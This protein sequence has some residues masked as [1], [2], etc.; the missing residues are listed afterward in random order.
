MQ[1]P[2]YISIP[3]EPGQTWEVDFF[4]PEDAASVVNLFLTVYGQGYPI[5]TFIQPERLIEENAA[6]RTISSVARTPRGDIVG[7][8]SLFISAPWEGIY[9]AGSGAVLPEYRGGHGIFTQLEAHNCETAAKKF[10]VAAIMAEPVCSHPFAQRVA[11]N[12][13]YVSCALEVDLMPAAAYEKEKSATG[14]VAALLGFMTR[15]PR[16]QLIYLPAVY[17]RQLRLIYSLFDDERSFSPSDG[18]LPNDVRT[19]LK[20]QVFDFAQVARL[21]VFEAGVDFAATITRE[22]E[23]VRSQGVVVI[24]VWLK[25]SWPWVGQTVEELRR[26]GYFLGGAMPRWFDDDGLL[27]QKIIGRPNWAGMK[28][29]YDWNKELVALVKA[30]WAEITGQE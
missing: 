16:P 19:C 4:R 29:E 2:T 3:I 25:L 13:G 21:A 5:K 22:E 14:R 10:G 30:D 18:V 11:H 23:A 24:Q 27:M 6:R 28:I 26:L 12:L 17:E 1:P 7:H 8:S 20:T 9:E 15:K